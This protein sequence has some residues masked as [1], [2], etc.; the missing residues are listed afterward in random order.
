MSFQVNKLIESG[1]NA[2]DI[3]VI[4]PYNLQ[5]KVKLFKFF[6]F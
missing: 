1:L 2:D 6:W 3:A 5:V 4:A